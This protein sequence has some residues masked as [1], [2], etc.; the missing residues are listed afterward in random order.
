MCKGTCQN[1]HAHTHTRTHTQKRR[2]IKG[3]EDG[4]DDGR[5]EKGPLAFP[6]QQLYTRTGAE[7]K[8]HWNSPNLEMGSQ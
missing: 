1:T 6:K 4:K 2:Q 3:N 8:D 7:K 5:D